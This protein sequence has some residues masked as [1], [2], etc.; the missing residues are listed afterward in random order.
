MENADQSVGQRAES[1]VVGL[2]TSQMGIAVAPSTWRPSQQRVR[3]A[4]AGV[5]QMAVARHTCEHGVMC[6]GARV[7]GGVPAACQPAVSST[8]SR[9]SGAVAHE[10]SRV[11]LWHASRTAPCVCRTSRPDRH[12]PEPGCRTF[13]GRRRPAPQARPGRGCRVA[14]AAAEER[15]ET[16][17]S[18][19]VALIFTDAT[20]HRKPSFRSF[21]TPHSRA[22]HA[23]NQAEYRRL[24]HLGQA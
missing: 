20:P 24:I 23:T 5:Y 15:H 8:P 12:D 9:L 10:S 1:L 21:R 16:L 6:S 17:G 2:T 13:R 14:P 7:I 19:S 22:R 11:P 4:E 3:P 18:T